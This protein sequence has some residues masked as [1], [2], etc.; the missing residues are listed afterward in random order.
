[1]SNDTAQLW[2]SAGTDP[3][4]HHT[5]P[6]SSHA[7]LILPNDHKYKRAALSFFLSPGQRVKMRILRLAS[8]PIGAYKHGLYE[9]DR[10]LQ[11]KQL[12][13]NVQF[14]TA[15]L[16]GTPGP[17]TKDTLLFL[18]EHAH[19]GAIAK[20]GTSESARR[21]LANEVRWLNAMAGRGFVGLVP[22]LLAE[23]ELNY[24]SV[25]IQSVGLGA[26][27]GRGIC[28]EIQEFLSTFQRAFEDESQ[29]STSLM[30]KMMVRRLELMK[31]AMSNTWQS[32]AKRT[33]QMLD[34]AFMGTTIPMVAAHRDFVP[35]NMRITPKGLFLFDWEFASEGYLPLYDLYHLLLMPSVLKG[36]VTRAVMRNAMDSATSYLETA[37]DGH[38][39]INKPEYQLLAYLL[40]L[41]LFYL[42]SNN[43][44]EEGDQVVQRYGKWIDQFDEWGIK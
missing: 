31:H 37:M 6:D 36:R 2:A 12:A 35:W 40:D 39:K 19:P 42:E 4:T 24:G 20:I 41:C 26:R 15:L 33:L 13:G 34:Q 27:V 14:R 38:Y 32:R 11:I 3:S 22:A 1:M 7:R 16:H 25:L 23:N 29:Y 10:L 21:L 28:K 17:Y 18:D 43:G 8:S 44:Q 30:R 5:Y 9:T